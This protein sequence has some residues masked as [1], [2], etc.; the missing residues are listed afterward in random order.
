MDRI[1]E[2]VP[3]FSEA[4]DKAK[5]E[6]IVDCFRSVEGVKLLDYSSDN[7]HN[8]TVVTVV[9]DVEPLKNAVIKAVG[10]AVE[11]LDLNKHQ[12][13]HPRMGAADVV[14]FIPIKGVTA[15]EAV[16]VSKEVGK[17]LWEKYGLP[18]FLYEKSAA[19]PARENLANIRKGE[20]EGLKEKMKDPLWHADFGGD[21]PHSTAGATVVGARMPLVAFNINV[22]TADLSIVD[23]VAK[24]VRFIGG[25]LR[26]CKAMGVE[27]TQRKQTQISMNMTDFTKTSLYFAY[28]LI[29]AELKRYNVK[30]VGSE[31]IGL[32]PYAALYDCAS[33]ALMCGGKTQAEVDMLKEEQIIS[34]AEKYLQ[35][36]DFRADQ[37]LEVKIRET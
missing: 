34:A 36:E 6:K 32:V 26:F 9:G 17:T 12:G 8:R 19:V 33:Y 3:N 4:R 7:D 20:Y 21:R 13:Q 30:I 31:I 15:E 10:V 27:L 2:C 22:D 37:V 24:K 11:I 23:R 28:E 35:I 18:I 5:V 25:G 29:K 1:L 14:P 16:L